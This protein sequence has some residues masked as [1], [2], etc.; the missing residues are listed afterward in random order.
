MFLYL[1]PLK[2]VRLL[3]AIYI[4]CIYYN[5]IWKQDFIIMHS[6]DILFIFWFMF[7]NLTYPITLL[8]IMHSY[9]RFTFG[10]QVTSSQQLHYHHR[11]LTLT[12]ILYASQHFMGNVPCILN[13]QVL[14][15]SQI[16]SRT[17]L[18]NNIVTNYLTCVQCIL[19]VLSLSDIIIKYHRRE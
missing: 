3:Q 17:Q 6:N 8:I 16:L 13:I 18:S 4:I 12:K 14:V 15:L 5:G 7:K 1:F 19:H 2:F 11:I 10:I 9:R